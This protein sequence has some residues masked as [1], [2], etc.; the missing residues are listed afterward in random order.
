MVLFLFLLYII[1]ILFVDDKRIFMI[2]NCLNIF[3]LLK[4]IYELHL[5]IVRFNNLMNN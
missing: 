1:L 4:I 2:I 5:E 3:F